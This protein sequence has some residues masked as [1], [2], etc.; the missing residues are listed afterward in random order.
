[1]VQSHNASPVERPLGAPP[2]AELA[3]KEFARELPRS[4]QESAWY[5][6]GKEGDR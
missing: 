2:E 3:A 4:E 5:Q 6:H 1:M